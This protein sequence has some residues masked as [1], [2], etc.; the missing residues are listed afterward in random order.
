MGADAITM[1]EVITTRLHQTDGFGQAIVI[2]A[3]L[4]NALGLQVEKDQPPQHSLDMI[5]EHP[6]LYQLYWLVLLHP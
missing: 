2:V 4:L 5:S 3:H 1:A 6:N